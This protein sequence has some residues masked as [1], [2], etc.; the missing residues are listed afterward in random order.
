M[1][2][3]SELID[4]MVA[5]T[6]DWQTLAGPREIVRLADLDIEEDVRWMRPANPIGSAVFEHHGIV[7]VGVI[8]KRSVRLSF[9]EGARLPALKKKQRLGVFATGVRSLP[10]RRLARQ[11]SRCHTHARQRRR[12]T[13]KRGIEV[14]IKVIVEL[15]ARPGKREELRSLLESVAAKNGPSAPGFL[16]STRYEVLEDPDALVEI[17]DWES[18]EAQTTA[19]QAVMATGAYEPLSEL[20]AVPFR[21]TVIRQLS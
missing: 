13:G 12:P 19:M 10:S 15:Q 2:S 6:P 5:K 8:L 17:A 11:T 7:C 3:R 4:D 16:G 20:L 9:W 21:A 18:A 1:A 14:A